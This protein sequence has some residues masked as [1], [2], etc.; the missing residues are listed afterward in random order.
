[1][2]D[3]GDSKNVVFGQTWNERLI[4]LF[5]NSVVLKLIKC[6]RA[7]RLDDWLA[8]VI[9]F[10]I[11]E[12]FIVNPMSSRSSLVVLAFSARIALRSGL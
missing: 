4:D 12:T 9:S 2:L 10:L 3:L 1:M 11:Y 5:T 8:Y 7:I 6:S